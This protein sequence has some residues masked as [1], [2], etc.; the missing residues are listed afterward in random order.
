MLYIFTPTYNR[1]QLLEKLFNSLLA[2]TIYDFNWLIVDDGS[3]DGTHQLIEGWKKKSP[4]AIKY[5]FKE[6]G[7]KHTAFNAALDLCDKYL[8]VCVDSDDTCESDFV[9]TI[10]KNHTYYHSV[11][12]IIAYVYP[13]SYGKNEFEVDE[14]A[15]PIKVNSWRV[16]KEIKGLKE[17]IRVFKPYVLEGFRFTIYQNEKFQPETVLWSRIARVGDALYFKKSLVKGNYLSGGMTDLRFK[18]ILSNPKGYYLSQIESYKFL[19]YKDNKNYIEKFKLLINIVS[20]NV[21]LNKSLLYNCPNKLL[22]I[23]CIPIGYIRGKK[24]KLR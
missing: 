8:N 10:M 16:S 20:L 9:E 3:T 12:N 24:M 4:F 21:A 13:N 23:L 2:Q 22:G 6:N 7:G 11:K 14:V 17:C 1:K 5:I 19:D 15:V 18:N